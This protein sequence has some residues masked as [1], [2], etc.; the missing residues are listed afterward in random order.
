MVTIVEGNKWTDNHES[1]I[2]LTSM[3]NLI[4]K[5]CTEV[6]GMDAPPQIMA[7]QFHSLSL[8]LRDQK[9]GVVFI[10]K[11][12]HQDDELHYNL[13][14]VA[15]GG[16]SE[17]HVYVGQGAEK[18][19]ATLPLKPTPLNKKLGVAGQFAQ[20][21]LFLYKNVGLSWREHDNAPLLK[22]PA[23]FQ[24]NSYPGRQ[25]GNSFSVGNSEPIKIRGVNIEEKNALIEAAK[26]NAL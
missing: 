15:A 26:G 21:S 13:T 24:K 17:F 7:Q 8:V 4:K 5:I 11:G 3:C 23:M 20:V 12:V 10:S 19:V 6:S 22:W 9:N 18:K 14:C 16:K 2:S 1:S 25:R